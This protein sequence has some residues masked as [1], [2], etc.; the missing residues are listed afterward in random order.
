MPF[1]KT[2]AVSFVSISNINELC[3]LNV[4]FNVKGGGTLLQGYAQPLTM[5]E[6]AQ[7]K[8]L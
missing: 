1:R 6:N 2:I 7:V 8:L 5:R 3:G 4:Q